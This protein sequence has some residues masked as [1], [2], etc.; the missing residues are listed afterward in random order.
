MTTL[1]QVDG[2]RAGYGE[3]RVLH[4]LSLTVDAGEVGLLDRTEWCREDNHAHGGDRTDR[5][6]WRHGSV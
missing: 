3:V 2:L 1:L 6:G 4:G 5:R